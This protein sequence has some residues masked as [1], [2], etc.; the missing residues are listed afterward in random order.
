MNKL[1]MRAG[2]TALVTLAL[3][4]AA[5]TPVHAAGDGGT[6]FKSKCAVCHGPNGKG[7][8]PAAKAMAAPDLTAP[9]TQKKTDAQ[10]IE[11]TTKGKAKMPAYEKTLTKAQITD[12]IAY[13]RELGKQK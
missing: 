9:A 8:T 2:C 5:V 10:L 7:D 13:I 3:A 12:A 1:L 6:L 4:L 11:T